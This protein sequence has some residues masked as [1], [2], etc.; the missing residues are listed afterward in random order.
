PRRLRIEGRVEADPSDI[1]NIPVLFTT[2]HA[3][4]AFVDAII[5]CVISRPP[6]AI[7]SP[8]SGANDEQAR[9]PSMAAMATTTNGRITSSE[10]VL[11]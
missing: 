11:P 6:G 4:F 10:E 5:L 8:D 9:E 1:R 2:S 3:S 7:G